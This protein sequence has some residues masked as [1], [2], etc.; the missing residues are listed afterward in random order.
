MSQE[1]HWKQAYRDECKKVAELRKKIDEVYIM[2]FKQKIDDLERENRALYR[3]VQERK[4]LYNQMEETVFF[5]ED[6]IMTTL[7][8]NARS[9]IWKVIESIKKFRNTTPENEN[10]FPP[11][12][13][14]NC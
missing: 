6:D 7:S 2:N 3:R 8:E 5:V 13:G 9:R 14:V 11:V 4:E 1:E 10:P 12:S